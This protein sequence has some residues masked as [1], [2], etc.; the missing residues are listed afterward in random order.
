MLKALILVL[1][2]AATGCAM[3]EPG[4]GGCAGGEG[5]SACEVER[6]SRGGGGY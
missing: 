5:S 6:S 2:F 3:V 1:A 4:Y